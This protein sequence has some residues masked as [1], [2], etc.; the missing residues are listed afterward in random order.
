MTFTHAE[1]L[2]LP[3][4][5]GDGT[6]REVQT[7]K[8]PHL[9]LKFANEVIRQFGGAPVGELRHGVPNLS[10]A[11]PLARTI[12]AG[13]SYSSAVRSVDVTD[14]YARVN[15]LGKQECVDV[16]VEVVTFIRDFDA[17]LYREYVA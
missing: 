10:H 12:M 6:F 13:L 2:L 3:V 5:N 14:N 9:A 7:K 8:Y 15:L 17:G 16:P 11:C 4:D 1:I